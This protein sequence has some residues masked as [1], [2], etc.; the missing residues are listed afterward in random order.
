MNAFDDPADGEVVHLYAQKL[1]AT[2][3]LGMATFEENGQPLGDFEVKELAQLHKWTIKTNAGAEGRTSPSEDGGGG[4]VILD[5]RSECDV[6]SDFPEI[7]PEYVG[8]KCRF[9]YSM[10]ISDTHD[11]GGGVPLF[12]KLLKH[13]FDHPGKYEVLDLND[14]STRSS[15]SSGYRGVGKGK[16]AGD[17]CFVPDKKRSD[18][19][20]GG[21]I[22]YFTHSLVHGEKEEGRERGLS[23]L[24]VVDA[25][26]ISAGPV[27]IVE[28]PFI[29][30]GF[31]ATWVPE[32]FVHQTQTP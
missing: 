32:E 29:P 15:S 6:H 28:L 9:G 14:Q 20:D 26:N 13:D 10:Q 21:W 5:S 1:A 16:V 23:W 7:N 24:E 17:L 31:H 2:G 18:S 25:Q 22:L 11:A 3:A 27:A 19:E 12:D 4:G 8:R 30:I